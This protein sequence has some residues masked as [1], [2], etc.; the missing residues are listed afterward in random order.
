MSDEEKDMFDEIVKNM[1]DEVREMLEKAGLEEHLESMKRRFEIQMEIMGL[2]EEL[3]ANDALH[4][5]VP[6][7]TSI[8][9]NSCD[10]LNEALASL[11]KINASTVRMIQDSDSMG[12]APWCPYNEDDVEDFDVDHQT[13]Q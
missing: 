11:S 10:D 3:N 7:L 8:V 2:L 5:I 13:K 4:C 6:I 9:V 12:I 1:P